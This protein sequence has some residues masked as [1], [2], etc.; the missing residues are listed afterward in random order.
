VR[1]DGS[2]E[3]LTTGALLLG[4]LPLQ[5]Y[6]AKE[7]QLSSG[8]VVVIYT[9]GYEAVNSQKRCLETNASRHW[10]GESCSFG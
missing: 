7:T 10:C 1:A 4:D 2:V 9:M 3:L 8:D 5:K 6:E